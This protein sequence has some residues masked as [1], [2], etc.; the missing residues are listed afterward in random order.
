M[1]RREQTVELVVP[2]YGMRQSFGLKHAERLLAMGAH[3]GGWELPANSKFTYDKD[4]GIRIKS[5]K[6]DT[7]KAE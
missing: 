1:K 4:N 6:G 7:A 2:K 3:N 5:D